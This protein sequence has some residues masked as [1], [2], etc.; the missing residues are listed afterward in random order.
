MPTKKTTNGFAKNLSWII[1]SF[2]MAMI[3]LIVI[4]F[5]TGVWNFPTSTM[6]TL[7]TT[8]IIEKLGL[9]TTINTPGV[10]CS[11]TFDKSQACIGEDVTGTIRDGSLNR[12]V[13]A[14]D[15]EDTGWAIYN[16]EVLDVDGVYSATQ[17]SDVV[18]T[19]VW[20]AL[21]G[22]FEGENFIE[23]CR[24]N[25]E[26][27]EIIL[28]EDFD[29]CQEVCEGEGFTD[30]WDALFDDG[31]DCAMAGASFIEYGYEGEDPILSCCC[32]DVPEDEGL[33]PGDVVGSGGGDV[34]LGDGGESS[35]EIQ[36]TPGEYQVDICAEIERR[37]S[38]VDPNCNPTGDLEDWNEFV[39]LDSYEVVWERSDQLVA[40]VSVGP[41]TYGNPDVVGVRWDGVTPFK[42]YMFHYG[43]CE[44]NME[45]RVSIV[46][47]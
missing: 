28:C 21:C 31:H 39:F 19:Y 37:S 22:H 18:G 43:P 38:K 9:G 36:L 17:S 41:D 33:E 47:C 7:D 45:M 35:F 8:M 1:P 4:L 34:T 44:M 14:Y 40:G 6:E 12:C 3:I 13:V 23:E 20:T 29:T 30:G 5:A 32:D 16:V 24:T 2:L 26:T 46:V 15:Y 27:I 11:F 10:I 25:D 42:G